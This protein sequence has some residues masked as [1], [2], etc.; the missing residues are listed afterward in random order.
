[1]DVY[2]HI[3]RKMNFKV[4]DTSYFYVCNAD[5]N[6]R[7]FGGKLNFTTTLVPY[8]TNTSWIDKKIAEMKLTLD[9]ENVPEINKSCERCMYLNAG[10][11][12]I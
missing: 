10:K 6:Y 8:K 12:F 4:S 7:K 3:L 5:R 11:D 1:M 9:S 2:V